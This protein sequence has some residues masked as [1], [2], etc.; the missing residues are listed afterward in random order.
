MS[1]DSLETVFNHSVSQNSKQKQQNKHIKTCWTWTKIAG[2]WGHRHGM[3]NRPAYI[4]LCIFMTVL[5]QQYWQLMQCQWEKSC[6]KGLFLLDNG[7]KSQETLFYFC[8]IKLS[9]RVSHPFTLDMP[10]MFLFIQEPTQQYQDRVIFI[11]VQV[12]CGK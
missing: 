5:L 11:Y 10:H 3:Q 1:D 6:L 7:K 4:T 9:R 2:S 12:E 8:Q